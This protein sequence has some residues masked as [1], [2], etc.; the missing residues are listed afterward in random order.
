MTQRMQTDALRSDEIVF[1][2]E[3]H[4]YTV[5]GE[6]FP[7]VTQALDLLNDF[8][9]VNAD[10]LERA[11]NFGTA[12]HEMV[13]L[14]VVGKL[15]EDNLDPV[16]APWLVTWRGWLH[17]T[18]QRILLSE[19]RVASLAHR[20]AGTLDLACI[21]AKTGALMVVDVKTGQIPATVGP[22]TAAYLSALQ[23]MDGYP[24]GA[25]MR[26]KPVRYCLSLTANGARLIPLKEESDFSIFL[27]ALNCYKFKEKHNGN[28]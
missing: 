12:V 7:S 13:R 11:R 28:H 25:S 18:Q 8:S 27:S 22:Q 20:Y 23:Q 4:R 19:Y 21:N 10:V 26:T 17:Q 15:D 14:D 2:A 5:R 3:L 9:K 16:L 24:F 6:V 1:D